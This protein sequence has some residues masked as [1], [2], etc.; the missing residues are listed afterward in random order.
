M[1]SIIR[2]ILKETPNRRIFYPYNKIEK[3]VEWFRDEYGD[4]PN[5]QGWDIFRSDSN[6][7]NKKY[8][9]K[10]V[11][12]G[13]EYEGYY[14]QIQKIDDPMED[15]A[16]FGALESDFTADELARKLG[17]MVDEY[18][19]VYGYKGTSFI[20]EL[21]PN[22][23]NESETK[24]DRFINYIVN[25]LKGKTDSSGRLLFKNW[26]GNP[27][28]NRLVELIGRINPQDGIPGSV[29]TYLSDTYHI[30]NFDI[31]ME[32]W[33][34]YVHWFVTHMVN[35][36]KEL[37]ESKNKWAKLHKFQDFIVNDLMNKT[38]SVFDIDGYVILTPFNRFYKF[39]LYTFEE[40]NIEY[41]KD[42]CEH[43]KNTYGSSKLECKLIWELYRR[44][45]LEKFGD[46]FLYNITESTDKKN[47]IID[48]IVNDILDKTLV[49]EE[50]NQIKF[51]FHRALRLSGIY[52]AP[53]PFVNLGASSLWRVFQIDF[54]EYL[55]NIYG[56]SD[57]EVRIVFDKM[58]KELYKRFPLKTFKRI[59]SLI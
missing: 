1:K 48:V 8:Y 59:R 55:K 50:K 32:I 56:S 11:I 42:F 47:S 5:R 46:S 18:G 45:V 53:R 4:Y 41:R 35:E 17:I 37:N 36:S 30:D 23:L 3:F 20:D 44:K 57:E 33:K 51:P 27:R 16:L 14:F 15:E 54:E 25:D 31:Q 43:I 12:N 21:Q 28:H 7:P 58:N 6:S 9:S 38:T 39:Y 40:D 2:K 13:K 22:S 19:V 52:S 24:V 29:D 49:S 10:G 26:K 34:R